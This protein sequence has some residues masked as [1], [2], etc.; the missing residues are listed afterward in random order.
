MEDLTAVA[1]EPFVWELLLLNRS[2]SL[3]IHQHSNNG[4]LLETLA[5]DYGFTCVNNVRRRGAN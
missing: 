1:M 4:I 5:V 2:H 3:S